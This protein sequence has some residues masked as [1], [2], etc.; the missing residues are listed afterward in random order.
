LSLLWSI[1]AL[2]RVQGAVSIQ[3]SDNGIGIAENEL[4]N[5]FQR[6]YR[7]NKMHSKKLGGSGLGLSIVETIVEKHFGKISVTSTLGE[8]STFTMLIA[9]NLESK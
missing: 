2:E 8:G 9:D 6:F 5:L 7:V 1:L 3:V 4:E